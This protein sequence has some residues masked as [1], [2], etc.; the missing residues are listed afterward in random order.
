MDQRQAEMILNIADYLETEVIDAE[1]DMKQYSTGK[2][3]PQRHPCGTTACAMGH[4]SAVY[5]DLIQLGPMHHPRDGSASGRALRLVFPNGRV[6]KAAQQTA[7]ARFFGIS[8]KDALDTFWATQDE[9]D[10]YYQRSV[11]EQVEKMRKLADKYGWVE[12]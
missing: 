8:V 1:L 3:T 6:V 5:P 10:G 4:G 12:A 11:A 2:I 7:V 9:V